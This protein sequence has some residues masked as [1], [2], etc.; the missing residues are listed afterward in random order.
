MYIAAVT[1]EWQQLGSPRT[2]KAARYTC[3]HRSEYTVRVLT[4]Y[5]SLLH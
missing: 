3:L 2:G 1:T 4:E 5:P